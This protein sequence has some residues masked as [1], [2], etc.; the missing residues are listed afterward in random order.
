MAALDETGLED[1][2]IVYGTSTIR[3]YLKKFHGVEISDADL[4]D[5]LT[6]IILEE[7]EEAEVNH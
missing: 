5:R 2:D 6:K 4:N 3:K 7:I 1:K